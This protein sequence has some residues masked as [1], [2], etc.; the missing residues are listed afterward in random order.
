MGDEFQMWC[1]KWAVV[2]GPSAAWKYTAEHDPDP[3]G[4]IQIHSGGTTDERVHSSVDHT[5]VKGGGGGG[6]GAP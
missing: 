2:D 4:R 5:A 6:G 1:T 3:D